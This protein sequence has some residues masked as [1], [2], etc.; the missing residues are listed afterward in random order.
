MPRNPEEGKPG[1]HD[2]PGASAL[3]KVNNGI[4]SPVAKEDHG[5][6]E[7]EPK[8]QLSNREKKKQG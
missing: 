3:P 5:D 7:E 4:E 8:P 6:P 2:P 1:G